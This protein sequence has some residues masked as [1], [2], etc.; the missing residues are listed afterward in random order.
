MFLCC[1]MILTNLVT[2]E[3]YTV[4]CTEIKAMDGDETKHLKDDNDSGSMGNDEAEN[5]HDS[6]DVFIGEEDFTVGKSPARNDTLASMGAFSDEMTTGVPG[7]GDGSPKV[8]FSDILFDN[9]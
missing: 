6:L 3:K 4:A 7:L 5:K 2:T 9:I 8:I 1:A